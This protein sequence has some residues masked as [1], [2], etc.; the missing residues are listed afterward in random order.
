M[1]KIAVFALLL[2]LAVPAL[3]QEK[4]LHKKMMAGSDEKTT[5]LNL[6][7]NLWEAFKNGDTKPFEERMT[8]GFVDLS[9]PA[10]TQ[11]PEFLKMVSAKTCTL[12]SYQVDDNAAELLKAGKDAAVLYYKVS[13]DGACGEQKMP[14]SMWAS[15]V[16]VKDGGKWKAAFHQ[17]SPAGE[18]PASAPTPGAQ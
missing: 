15:T 2:A 11:R 10:P 3:A 6:E 4:K 18:M 9:G 13:M 7:K 1:R 12:N 14:S 8:A 17:E 16:W 5:L